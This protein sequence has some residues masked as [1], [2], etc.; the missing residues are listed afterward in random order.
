M[1]LT[2]Y[3][4]ISASI[5]LLSACSE[6]EGLPSVNNQ[7]A[8]TPQAIELAAGIV[9]GGY[10]GVETRASGVEDH[11][12]KHVLMDENSV[13][14]LLVVGDWWKTATEFTAIPKMAIGK[15]GAIFEEGVA[16]K[17]N[18]HRKLSLD[19]VLNWDDYG[20]ADPNNMGTGK[21]RKK[22]L[23]IYGVTVAGVTD[24]ANLP[25][26]SPVSSNALATAW[27]KLG[28]TLPAD[29]NTSGWA[30]EDLLIS[31]NVQEQTSGTDPDTDHDGRYKFDEKSNGKLLEFKHAMSKI[32]VRLI[33]S[34]GF[35]T[36]GVGATENKFAATPEV[37]LTSNMS[38]QTNTEW[39][40]TSGKV[41]IETGAV[42]DQATPGVITMHTQSTADNTYTVIYDA[43]IMPGSVFANKGAGASAY[44]T[45]ASINADG[46]I[47]Y[48]TSEKIR[49]KI[50]T[51]IDESKHNNEYKVEPGKNYI[52]TVNVKKTKIEVTATVR[53]WYDVDAEPVEPV[54]NVS[55][56]IGGTSQLENAFEKFDFYL[57]DNS[58]S[59]FATNY[60]SDSKSATAIAP[61]S[62]N[63]TDGTQAWSF[64]S[65]LYWPSHS[66]HYH[67]RGVYPSGTT[68]TS[69]KI[70][71]SNGDYNATTS[72]SNLLVGA[73]V[74]TEDNKNCDN[75]DHTSVDMSINGICA[76]EATINLSFNYMMSQVEVRLT[77]PESGND[78]VNLTNA[79]VEIIGG[80]TSGNVD[81]H[82]KTVAVSGSAGNSE[83]KH[84]TGEDAN[85]RHSVVVPQ[86]L[87]HGTGETETD[88]KFRIT[89]YK[90]GSTTDID[91]VYVAVVKNIKVS[92]SSI[93]ASPTFITSWD[94]GKHYVYTLD[95]RKT[96]VKVTATI[97]DW[98]TVNASEDI[99]F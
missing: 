21:G 58:V 60:N 30:N 35:P 53:D 42:E 51:L 5:T 63:K 65:P 89:I 54:I 95:M 40:Y 41:N 48:I 31:N 59:G 3:L 23:A 91:D 47:Y 98:R 94:S 14:R 2:H 9:Q 74:F 45:I 29:Q 92:D 75:T 15:A 55:T 84:V 68:V 81:V 86:P 8:G 13:M 72:P 77:T 71:V 44:P 27:N 16:E 33:A 97:T 7:E 17:E 93:S 1:K 20:T 79:K 87:S 61:A 39:V 6:E 19:P 69:G 24:A 49:A 76:R 83:I 90:S 37:K 50:K 38:G 12:G 70:V 88:L 62:G 11:H 26:W 32:T 25:T 66:T 36:T 96:E 22:G 28:W 4:Y 73:P 10:S 43:L 78:E 34:D 67:M 80:Y 99:W 64:S 82:T 57:S 52:I 46:N 85:Y 56:S 18:T